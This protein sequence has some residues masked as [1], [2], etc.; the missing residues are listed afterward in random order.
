[1]G[2]GAGIPFG[3]ASGPAQAQVV[4]TTP[5]IASWTNG[6]WV[7]WTPSATNTGSGVTLAVDSLSP[8]TV[9]KCGT[10]PLTPGDLQPN[11]TA[12]AQYDA[13]NVVLNLANPINEC[14][15]LPTTAGPANAQTVTIQP[16]VTGHVPGQAYNMFAG[17][18]N[19]GAMTLNIG[20]GVW[21]VTK[22]GGA[23][24]IAN[25]WPLTSPNKTIMVVL[26]DGVGFQL[27]N[28]MAGSC[29]AATNLSPWTKIQVAHIAAGCTVSPCV[30]TLAS[31]GANHALIMAT[32]SN[33]ASTTGAP[34]AGACNVAWIHGP[35]APAAGS[36]NTLDAYYCPQSV[37]GVTS[38][39]QPITSFTGGTVDV[40]VWEAAPPLPTIAID[41]G[42]NPANKVADATCTSC[43]GVP[44]TLSGNANFIIVLSGGT[45]NVSGLTGTGFTYDGGSNFGD[46]FGSG[47]TT[48]SLTAPATWTATSGTLEA[49]ALALQAH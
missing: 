32:L 7:S 10:L 9:D 22:C 40:I 30:V 13:V 29:G 31:T 45:A 3:V 16:P 49:Y 18:S 47:I 42:A 17:I 20:G 6:Q 21:N 11:P 48:G 1:V 38:F 26:D 41:S 5:N 8:V 25:D 14:P 43:A 34:P 19:T 46:S 28:P 39:S 27:N 24:L 33:A 2:G 37:S 23:S 4:T 44:L 35:N 12:Y 15:G 36:G